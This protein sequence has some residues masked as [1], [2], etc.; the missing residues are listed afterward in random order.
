MIFKNIIT[1]FLLT[2]TNINSKQIFIKKKSIISFFY[3]N[4]QNESVSISINNNKYRESSLLPYNNGIFTT[5]INKGI[6][7]V[8][9]YPNNIDYKYIIEN[10][11]ILNKN[12][13]KHDIVFH[14]NKYKL[15]DKINYQYN[16]NHIL[17]ISSMINF[18]SFNKN[19]TYYVKIL[20]DN[21]NFESIYNK[22]TFS[23]ISNKIYLKKG[24]HSIKLLVKSINNTLCS[25]ITANKGFTYGRFL[26]AWLI[27]NKKK[28]KYKSKNKIYKKN[29]N[30]YL[31][32]ICQ[33]NN[34]YTYLKSFE[35]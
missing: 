19:I 20:I 9:I 12:K 11:I 10:G 21:I 24:N 1:L 8:S 32:N 35:I 14:K 5:N 7:N 26:N 15:L 16:S 28:Y 6:Y 22:K 4:Y 33:N 17:K 13:I 2:I 29:N 23:Y 3:Y 18:A 34:I 31:N 30:I 27:N 25:C